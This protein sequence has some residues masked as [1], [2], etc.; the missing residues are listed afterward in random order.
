MNW[1]RLAVASGCVAVFVCGTATACA[2]ENAKPRQAR[3]KAWPP[4]VSNVFFADAREHLVGKR[5]DKGLQPNRADSAPM[6]VAATNREIN[7]GLKWSRLVDGE[8][9][10]TEVKRIIGR[11]HEPLANAT[12]F[13]TDGFKQCQ[14]DFGQLSVLFGVIAEYDGEVRWRDDA[15]GLRDALARAS[16]NCKKATDQTLA[17]ATERVADLDDVVRGGRLAGEESALLENW[18]TLADRSILMLRMQTAWRNNISPQLSDARRFDKSADDVR[19]EAQL[20][21]TLAEVIHREEYEYWD[22]ESFVDYARQLQEASTSL[23][24]AAADG[25]YEAARQSSARIG[26]ACADCHDGYRG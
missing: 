4:E 14:A 7:G 19:H 12:Q 16:R 21:A 18:S 24:R 20:L 22:D 15:A 13:K 2:A 23:S 25:N 11:L 17:E 26:Q 5:P 10:A 8:T 6:A 3:P 1:V 9:L